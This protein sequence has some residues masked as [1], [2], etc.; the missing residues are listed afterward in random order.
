MTEHDLQNSIRLEL[1]KRGFFTERINV[2][3]GYLISAKMMDAIKKACPSLRE[4]LDKIP[5]FTTGAVNGRS[6]LSAVKDG[7]THYI[8][9]KVHPNKPSEEQMNFLAVMRDRYGCNGGV[10]YSVDDAI[11]IV[12]GGSK[13]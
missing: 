4:V 5:Y 10:A 1:S 12:Y 8:E 6:D 2:G 13:P 11:E 9:V 3:S 7:C